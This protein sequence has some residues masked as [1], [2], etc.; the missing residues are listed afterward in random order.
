METFVILLS[1][2]LC[3]AAVHAMTQLWRWPKDWG[4][5]FFAKFFAG[6]SIVLSMISLLKGS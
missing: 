6:S 4:Y 1:M 5:A 2:V 3:G